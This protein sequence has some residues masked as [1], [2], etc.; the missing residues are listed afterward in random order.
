MEGTLPILSETQLTLYVSC[1][2][3]AISCL[4]WMTFMNPV[5]QL[6]SNIPKVVQS[7]NFYVDGTSSLESTTELSKCFTRDFKILIKYNK[8][9]ITWNPPSF[10][11]CFF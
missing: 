11:Y 6:S 9:H 7:C 5:L 2:L 3:A 4:T 8:I 1:I 10:I